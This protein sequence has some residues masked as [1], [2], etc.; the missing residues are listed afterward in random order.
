MTSL[1]VSLKTVLTGITGTEK[2]A[3][4]KRA[5][6]TT[7]SFVAV[8]FNEAGKGRI[9]VIPNGATLQVIGRSSG[10]PEGFEVMFD[11]RL[12]HVFK[13]DLLARS[14]RLYAPIRI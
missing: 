8:H 4:A 6:R 12:Y 2:D 10:L 1:V 3:P 11:K 14:S 5:Y 13:I 7:T 9:A